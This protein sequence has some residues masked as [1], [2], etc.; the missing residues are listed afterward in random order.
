MFPLL[1]FIKQNEIKT[2]DTLGPELVIKLYWFIK[3]IL[4]PK[5]QLKAQTDM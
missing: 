2:S 1:Q 4:R 3:T 5:V